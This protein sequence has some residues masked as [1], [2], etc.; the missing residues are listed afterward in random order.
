MYI[1]PGELTLLNNACVNIA[2]PEACACVIPRSNSLV[3]SF[4]SSLS[5]DLILAEGNSSS[6]SINQAGTTFITGPYLDGTG[7]TNVTTQISTH[8]Y[9]PCKVSAR[10]RLLFSP[11]ARARDLFIK[12]TQKP[13]FFR[14]H[15]INIFFLCTSLV[16]APVEKRQ[17]MKYSRFVCISELEILIDENIFTFSL[18]IT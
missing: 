8:A 17:K 2:E 1:K 13:R 14:F 12:L 7:I 18:R 10:E 4:S 16:E 6:V 3:V 15:F 9:L 11:R 5:A